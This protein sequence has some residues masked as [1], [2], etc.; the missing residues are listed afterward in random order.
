MCV[1][2]LQSLSTARFV[3]PND[4]GIIISI[5]IVAAKS[6]PDESSAAVCADEKMEIYE[7]VE[8]D[9]NNTYEAINI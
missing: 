9:T 4:I 8:M 7:E 3:L 1:H 6:A 5:V 2:L